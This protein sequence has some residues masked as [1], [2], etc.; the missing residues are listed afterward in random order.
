MNNSKRWALFGF[1]AFIALIFLL[2]TP[3]IS[4]EELLPEYTNASSHFL[5]F[6]GTDLHYRDEGAG[7]PILLIHGTF[8]SL[9]TWDRF[10]EIARDTL[11]CVR[12]DLPGFGLSGPI[13]TEDYSDGNMIAAFEQLRQ[14]LGLSQWWVAGNSLGGRLAAAYAAEHPQHIKGYVLIDPSALPDIRKRAGINE[15]GERPFIIKLAS[16]PIL[17]NLIRYVTPRGMIRNNIRQ[18]YGNPDLVT[19]ALIQ[20]YM[21]MQLREGNR[22]AVVS[23]LEQPALYQG[24]AE[25]L[26][27][28]P[29]LLIW[30][31]KD[32]WIPPVQADWWQN[33][34]PDIKNEKKESLGHVPME[35]D[36]LWTSSKVIDFIYGTDSTHST[37]TSR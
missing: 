1:T 22:D 11:R 29:G 33:V 23:R 18:V 32:T 3:D 17:N 34:V 25:P 21:D 5:E 28:L 2:Y 24:S 9:H 27:N 13:E 12:L 16:T 37:Q 30:G 26:R 6:Q 15:S 14:N 10:V 31:G 20:R 8:S 36:P 35:E 19:D 7:E 4:L